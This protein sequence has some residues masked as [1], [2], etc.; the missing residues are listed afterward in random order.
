MDGLNL[1]ST[2]MATDARHSFPLT[3]TFTRPMFAGAKSETKID[4]G[5]GARYH[6]EDLF[7]PDPKIGLQFKEEDAKLCLDISGRNFFGSPVYINVKDLLENLTVIDYLEY[8][9]TRTSG[10]IKEEPIEL[11][12]SH[13]P[14]TNKIQDKNPDQFMLVQD[15]QSTENDVLLNIG[16]ISAFV[17]SGITETWYL[18]MKSGTYL[19]FKIT[20]QSYGMYLERIKEFLIKRNEDAFY[21]DEHHLFLVVIKTL[22][23]VK[24]KN[25]KL[26]L[27]LKNGK[28]LVMDATLK[29]YQLLLPKLE[30][31]LRGQNEKL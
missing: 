2:I 15:D 17:Y 3:I 20:S 26:Y 11:E 14:E 1:E 4:F 18:Q 12:E 24:F 19:S 13:I 9:D 8:L 27:H 16:D 23:V 29:S 7:N 30:M 10:M 21:Y 5:Y 28:Y 31:K 25:D 22:A 6:M